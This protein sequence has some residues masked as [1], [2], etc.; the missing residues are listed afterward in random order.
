[1]FKALLVSFFSIFLL[2][3]SA[4]AQEMVSTDPMPR[5]VVIEEFTG[6]HCVNCPKGHKASQEMVDTYP[7]KVFAINIHAGGYASPSDGEPDLRTDEGDV[8]LSK[9]GANFF[10]AASINRST[11]PWA[12]S[13]TEMTSL[14][15]AIMAETSPVNLAVKSVV[16]SK[17]RILTTDVEYYYTDDSPESENYLTVIL[18]QSKIL[19]PQS[20][21]GYYPENWENG[22][23]KHNHA[24]RMAL[25]EGELYRD[26]I[27]T[28]T[29]ESFEK[30]TYTVTLPEKIKGID[31]RL[32]DCEVIAFITE[33]EGNIYSAAHA[34]VEFTNPLEEISTDLELVNKTE[35]PT[36]YCFTS[37]HPIAEVTNKSDKIIKSFELTAILD[38]EEYTKTFEGSLGENETTTIDWG[39]MNFTAEGT[40]KIEIEGIK[41]I[42]NNELMDVNGDNDKVEHSGVGV[43]EKAFTTIRAGFNTAGDPPKNVLFDN[44]QNSQFYTLW[45]S[46]PYGARNSWCAVVFLIHS[47]RNVAGKP[48]Y[49]ILGEAELTR[50]T[51]PMLSYYYAYSD[52]N[53]G[54][55]APTIKVEISDDCGESWNEIAAETL[56]E[57]GQ[58]GEDGKIYVPL[59]SE[60]KK[61][62]MSLEE[63]TDN[64]V[65][66]R[67]AGIPGTSGSAFYIDEIEI[68]GTVGVQENESISDEA[69]YPNPT[70]NI[71][72]FNTDR[73]LGMEYEVYSL[74]G[75]MVL[76]GRNSDNSIDISNLNNG[77]YCI[78]INDNFFRV[79]KN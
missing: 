15:T 60:F 7:G 62:S 38:G 77:T 44:S 5:N 32:Y 29:K 26:P 40:Y 64:D 31:L 22:L 37:I 73:F 36:D 23:Y 55:T 21:N 34:E 67:V 19:G 24:L 30:R 6:I 52:G 59:T 47:S 78:K 70:D 8:F 68:S 4:R 2:A 13:I 42:N 46:A 16:D 65:L 3:I 79:I 35:F 48:G 49:I 61:V 9:A 56:E 54:G 72:Y 20:D 66:I 12:Q 43:K 17:T 58:P 41:N 28:T 45:L 76:K 57:T 75:Y 39:E 14:A 18:T 10:P 1:M 51:D 74:L 69:I 53:Y 27:A 25:S 50:V 33:G 63:Y 11:A 71:V